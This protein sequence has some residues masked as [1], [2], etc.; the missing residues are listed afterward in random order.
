[1]L[2]QLQEWMKHIQQPGKLGNNPN[3]PFAA[4]A[5]KQKRV[6]VTAH[7]DI[8]DL[9][10]LIDEVDVTKFD[11]SIF[12]FEQYT[13]YTVEELEQRIKELNFRFK[14]KDKVILDNDPR[15]PFTVNGHQTTFDRCYLYVVQSLSD[16]TQ[17]SNR[18]KMGDYYSYWTQTQYD[19]VVGWR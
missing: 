7:T 4:K 5:V 18:L 2:E 6:D 1:M 8:R 16:L 15:N 12:Y 13:E 3:S 11:V 17:A 10:M 9:E 19:E 14:S